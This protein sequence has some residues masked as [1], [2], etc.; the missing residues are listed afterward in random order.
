[1]LGYYL[2]RYKRCLT[3][4]LT[5]C[6]FTLADASEFP[7]GL[8]I[9]GS[10][11]EDQGNLASDPN[12]NQSTYP[13]YLG[14][15]FGLDITPYAVG[16]TDF[17]YA[18]CTVS[19]LI[20]GSTPTMFTQMQMIPLDLSRNYPVVVSITNKNDL[21]ANLVDNGEFFTI[22][23][24]KGLHE[25]GFKYISGMLDSTNPDIT[26]PQTV[27]D[28]VFETIT[29]LQVDALDFSV[30]LIDIYSLNKAIRKNPNYFGISDFTTLSFP[31]FPG[32]TPGYFWWNGQHPNTAGYQIYADYIFALFTA[33]EQ[34]ATL[35]RYPFGV[36]RE[37]NH[38][39]L[40]QL[41]PMQH[42]HELCTFYPFVAADGTPK[43]TPAHKG[44]RFGNQRSYGG[45]VTIGVTNRVTECWT[46]GAAVA[47]DEQKSK[48][49]H[50]RNSY[51]DTMNTEIIS[52]FAGY[53]GSRLY[54]NGIF[55]Y[56]FIQYRD[57]KRKYVIGA[58][59][60]T[61][62][63]HTHGQ[64]YAFDFLGGYHLWKCNNGIKT[65]PIAN[66]EYQKVNVHRYTEHGAVAG[67]VQFFNQE[68]RSF[69][70]GLGWE[71]LLEKDMWNSLVTTDLFLMANEQWIQKTREI[72]FREASLQFN[73][74]TWPVKEPQTF[75][76]S[77]GLDFSLERCGHAFTLGYQGNFGEHNFQ[78][79]MFAAGYNF[80]W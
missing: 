13:I 10:S 30:L 50:N 47:F 24:L 26:F 3:L 17:A 20:G 21:G 58:S 80:A 64:V 23:L 71:A 37:Q 11:L 32:A 75:Y 38:A 68:N 51:H 29:P 39:I 77:A 46:V 41:Y 79:H 72:Q 27:Q 60:N 76:F 56:G 7:Q 35:A 2:N 70:T 25:K 14:D 18:G 57:I 65:G 15:R 31:D 48:C 34:Y 1:M 9:I 12:T 44:S 4:S 53:E 16:G 54:V 55:D 61:A 45:D 62:K 33:P 49:S 52:G 69:I 19:P 63:G 73:H 6:L 42:C 67:N 36:M 43:M 5:C 66:I 59:M 78:E 74:G 8:I 28:Y 40:Q 22:E